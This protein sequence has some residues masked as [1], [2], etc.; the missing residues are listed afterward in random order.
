MGNNH[1]K[2][3]D[4]TVINK[5]RKLLEALWDAF[6]T[7]PKVTSLPKPRKFI[8]DRIKKQV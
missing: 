1:I 7:A 4:K 6:A 3:T 2:S 8:S 5:N